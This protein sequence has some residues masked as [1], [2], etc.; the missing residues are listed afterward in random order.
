MADTTPDDAPKP[1]RGGFFDR[2]VDDATEAESVAAKVFVYDGGVRL[3]HWVNALCIVILCVTG[4]LIA[5][6]PP[7]VPG[8]ASENFLF[9]YIRMF[10]FAAGQVLAVM[11]LFRII[12][13]FV[14]N[15]HARQLFLPPVWSGQWWKEVLFEFR[16]YAFLEPDPKKYIGHNPLAQIAMFTL[17]V[18]P[19]VVMIFTGF[20]L[21]A[22][23]Q[24][25]E[26]WW[27]AVFGWVIFAL[28]GN[29]F[30]VHTVHHV[31]MWV[32]ILFTM[33]HIYAAIREDIMSRQSL[34]S[35]MI[36]GWRY[37]KDDKE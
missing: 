11:F 22:E 2:V 16:W 26:S 17:F 6:P 28:G 3:W 9:G 33:V 25:T 36:S 14:G 10:H 1:K 18:I 34:V 12:W 27:F 19:M 23:G 21:Y 24:G 8:E 35:T 32:I 15:H 7:S 37:F 5:S 13:A 29:S 4:Y 30:F 20:A 31:G